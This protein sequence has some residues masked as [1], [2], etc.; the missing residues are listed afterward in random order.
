MYYT[1]KL[2]L[3]EDRCLR[4]PGGVPQEKQKITRSNQSSVRLQLYSR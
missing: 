3:N 2:Y 4:N 1:F